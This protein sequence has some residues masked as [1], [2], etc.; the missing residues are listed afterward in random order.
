MASDEQ[1][2]GLEPDELPELVRRIAPRWFLM[3]SVREPER[4]ALVQPR[5][6]LRL[7]AGAHDA[8]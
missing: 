5:T 7:D 4:L 1:V 6:T 8:F 3:R 2:D